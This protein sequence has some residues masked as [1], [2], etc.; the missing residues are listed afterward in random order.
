MRYLLDT[1][2]YARA[3]EPAVAAVWTQALRA[4]QIVS[5]GPFVTEALYSAR[6]AQEVGA[7]IEE[8]TAGL[9]YLDADAE[10]WR[11]AR[12]GLLEM[13]GVAPQFHRRPPV[14]FLIAALAHQHELSV[15]HYDSDYDLIGKH[16]SLRYESRWVVPQG[17]LD[18]ADLDVLRPYRRGITARLGQFTEPE[19][20]GV[21]ERLIAMLDNEIATAGKQPLKPVVEG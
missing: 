15:L 1:S 4:N 12:E 14:D 18:G 16:T 7:L 9:F 13:A 5:C 8:L 21:F 2:V 6:D 11:L 10:T 20:A 3:A 17:T 19:D